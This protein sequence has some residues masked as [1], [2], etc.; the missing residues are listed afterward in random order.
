[1]KRKILLILCVLI[2]IL[3]ILDIASCTGNIDV[4]STP[5]S[6]TLANGKIFGK[7]RYSN[8]DE[9]SNG[10]IIVT[11][12]KMDVKTITADDGSYI[13]E[14]LAEGVYTVSAES[15]YSSEKAVCTNVV[16]H[17][18]Q[19]TI[20]ESLNL[21]ATG[22]ITGKITLDNKDT[23]NSGFLVFIAGT[24]YMAITDDSGNYKISGV[25]AGKGYLVVATK[26][27]VIHSLG[28]N[29][30]VPAN[31][32]VEIIKNNFTRDELKGKK[33]DKGEIG[34]TGKNIVWLGSFDDVSEIGEP[35][36]L[37]AYFN[38][39][40]GCSY[41]WDGTEWKLLA[42]TGASGAD[43]FS[44]LVIETVRS[45][46][47]LTN[48]VIITVNVTKNSFLKIGYVY[49]V[50]KPDFKSANAVLRSSD[51]IPI[52]KDSENKYTIEARKNGYYT[53][54]AKDTDGF[55]DYKQEVLTNLDPVVPGK[56]NALQVKYNLNEKVLTATWTNPD[57]S[58][59]AYVDFSYTKDGTLQIEDEHT[60]N[61]SYSINNVG[62]DGVEYEFTLFAVDLAGNTSEVSSV[63]VA[64][65]SVGDV[66]LN[67]G[68]IILYDAD[69]LFFTD[70]QKEKVVGVLYGK[71][72][73]GRPKGW[74]G[75][76]NSANEELNRRLYDWSPSYATKREFYDIQCVYNDFCDYNDNVYKYTITG[77][78]D[79][80]DNWAYI[81]SVTPIS[82]SGFNAIRKNWPAFSYV[83]NYATD[84]GLT[85]NYSIGW[86]M[87]SLAELC[88]IYRNKD[89]LNFVLK[90]LGGVMLYDSENSSYWSS[91]QSGSL[92]WCI[93]FSSGSVES[94]DADSYKYVCCIRY[95]TEV[96]EK[97][98]DNGGTFEAYIY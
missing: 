38:K 49:S 63:K 90:I 64:P 93:D 29:V 33:G 41:I 66:L 57:D 72:E 40:N 84:N 48:K 5:K 71:D 31:A 92:T 39:T 62:I 69:N 30:N 88:M 24:S 75:K 9:S 96:E 26:N 68:T 87:P 60:K 53:I 36:Y 27:D 16:V 95:F 47:D 7:V 20:A 3:V 22:G 70:E 44:A 18:S 13:F 15:S 52:T 1:M 98:E 11:L 37:N 12:E 83:N 82:T 77:D 23:G 54:A 73:N 58:D 46:Y 80:R 79:G 32:F 6:Q 91:S 51:F 50:E 4:T 17:A 67:D 2:T 21:I 19:T 55:V 86:Y 8:L 85:N 45:T 42:R 28:T 59:L 14:N 61:E 10:G 35:E 97:I 65:L 34:E 74:L 76:N 25:P 81:C 89:V 94:S 43:C 78:T 56:I